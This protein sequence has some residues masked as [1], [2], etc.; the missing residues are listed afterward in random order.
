MPFIVTTSFGFEY[1]RPLLPLFRY[2]GP[3]IVTGESLKGSLKS[4]LDSKNVSTVVYISMGTTAR[5]SLSEVE[6]ITRGILTSSYSALW[7]LRDTTQHGLVHAIAGVQNMHRFFLSKWLPQ[8]AILE[9]RSIALAITHGGMGRVSQCLYSGIPEIM[10]P[11]ANDQDDIA[12]RVVSGGAGIKIDKQSVTI[13]S[14]RNA[15]TIVSSSKYREAALRFRKIFHQSGGVEK[16]G[17]LIE[18]YVDV[19]CKHLIPA[20]VRYKWTTIQYYNIDVYAFVITLSLLLLYCFHNVLKC[21]YRGQYR[22]VRMH[23]WSLCQV[24]STMTPCNT[25]KLK[26]GFIVA[27]TFALVMYSV[28]ITME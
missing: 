4:W 28:V 9:H 12:A 1:S 2:V 27:V 3:M 11:D 21:W 20:Y 18:F 6:A 23:M 5:L 26:L 13:N 24:R 10:L 14:I 15:I 25:W 16:A 8:Q 7:S 17:D 22:H 19:G